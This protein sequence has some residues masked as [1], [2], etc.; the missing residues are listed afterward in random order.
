MR[1]LE[2]VFQKKIKMLLPPEINPFR[3]M[4]HY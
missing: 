3:A 1:V 2:E 4:T